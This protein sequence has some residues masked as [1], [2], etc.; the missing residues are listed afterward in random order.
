MLQ[1]AWPHDA[2]GSAAVAVGP[3]PVRIEVV[4]GQPRF[5]VRLWAVSPKALQAGLEVAPASAAVP[6]SLRTCTTTDLAEQ[7]SFAQPDAFQRGIVTITNR[8]STDCAVRSWPTVQPLDAAL[9]QIGPSPDLDA[10]RSLDG[11]EG[12]ADAGGR[13][14]PARLAAGRHGYF[15][16]DFD[17]LTD[18]R[19]QDAR[20]RADAAGRPVS[21]GY[22]APADRTP[23]C[24]TQP[25]AALRFTVGPAVLTVPVGKAGLGACGAIAQDLDL[26]PVVASR[27]TRG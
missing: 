20:A 16:T 27:P 7:A 25:V 11:A 18:L 26:D 4:S 24:D 15:I 17:T 6:A 1:P 23:R 12:A 2:K 13:F 21:S 9:Q 5:V 22:V 14:P 8:S 10:Q 19:Q 3:V